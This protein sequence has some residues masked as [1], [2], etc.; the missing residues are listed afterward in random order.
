M[1]VLDNAGNELFV[2]DRVKFVNKD[3]GDT[4]RY[5]IGTEAIVV[6]F[7]E[8]NEDD[9]GVHFEDADEVGHDLGG[10]LMDNRGWWINRLCIEKIKSKPTKSSSDPYKDFSIALS[11]KKR[12]MVVDNHVYELKEVE[13][14]H[15][16]SELLEARDKESAQ[17][18]KTQL[19]K[20]KK[21]EEELIAD[22]RKKLLM[23]DIDPSHV[24]RGLSVY[25][26]TSG[27]TYASKM[28]YAPKFIVRDKTTYSI[29]D[30]D[31]RKI[32]KDV[33]I[34]VK[35]NN[36]GAVS[37]IE[38]VDDDGYRFTRFEH[39]H[40]GCF[41]SMKFPTISNSN[42]ILKLRD[43]TQSLLE[44][45]NANSKAN[46]HPQNMPTYEELFK[47][48]KLLG[49]SGK[50]GVMRAMSF[51]AVEIY[52]GDRVIVSRAVDN[53]PADKV[54]SV[55]KVIH[56]AENSREELI[57]GVEFTFKH[58]TFHDAHGIGKD[59]HCYYFPV[60]Y[61]VPIDDKDEPIKDRPQ[62]EEKKR[63]KP[64]KAVG[65]GVFKV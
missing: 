2:N 18:L 35:I 57:I 36:Y 43:K 61:V 39:Y 34:L 17:I 37:Y 13:R 55:G 48:S 59:K 1:A 23:P 56:T 38:V 25:K 16:A 44:T 63:T 3:H 12:Y 52:V 15:S 14:I 7:Q 29:S 65:E 42:D 20:L 46:D 10:K 6:M 21:R 32:E 49:D 47:K 27:I 22:G 41:G 8:E 30:A 5:K 33:Y 40:Q 60:D 28:K 51:G 19:D 64:L 31:Q 58:D 9:I 53:F 11:D 26:D 50:A 24:I 45:V 54:G 62:V 4:P